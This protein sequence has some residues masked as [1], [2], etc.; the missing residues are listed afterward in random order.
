LTFVGTT[1]LRT[2][3][4]DCPNKIGTNRSPIKS[5]YEDR[6]TTECGELVGCKTMYSRAYPSQWHSVVYKVAIRQV[7]V[8]VLP[9]SLSVSFHQCY[10]LAFHYSIVDA[11]QSSQ[12]TASLI[13][14]DG[15]STKQNSHYCG[16]NNDYD[17]GSAYEQTAEHRIVCF[18]HLCSTEQHTCRTLHI[19]H[20]S[21][22]RQ[23][24]M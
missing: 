18:C 9:F 24:L 23:T 8:R 6:L 13:R 2:R 15:G 1:G 20:L 10:K 14:H 21:A 7:S 11:T 12:L 22:I 4:W 19:T 16:S 5:G 17:N 3:N